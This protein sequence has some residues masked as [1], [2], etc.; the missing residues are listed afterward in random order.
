MG[1]TTRGES[2]DIQQRSLAASVRMLGA[3]GK[4]SELYENEVGGVLASI[5]PSAPAQTIVNVVSYADSHGLMESLPAVHARY[6]EVGVRSHALWVRWGDDLRE[7]LTEL[8]YGIGARLPAMVL[9]DLPA[10]RPGDDLDGFRFTSEEKM[11]TLGKVNAAARPDGLGLPIAL[12]RQPTDPA[13][14]LYGARERDRTLSVLMTIDVEADG[15][16]DCAVGFVATRPDAQRRGL[17]RAL[18][19]AALVE[20]RTRGCRTSSLQA[21]AVGTPLY[22]SLGYRTHGQYQLYVFKGAAE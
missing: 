8:G 19:S 5:V 2:R 13:V 3:A 18:L 12:N 15:E 21:S 17:A 4:D 16:V 20:A 22:D 11:A 14:R 10:W 9:D 1:T 6:A 7:P